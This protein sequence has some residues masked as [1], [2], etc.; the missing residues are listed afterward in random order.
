[1]IRIRPIRV[2]EVPAAKHMILSVAYNIYG[3][4]GTLEE[5]IRHFEESGEFRDMDEVQK[6]YFENDGLFLAVLDDNRVIGTGAIRRLDASACEL[7][8]MWLLEAYHGRGIGY[9]VFMQLLNFARS[10]NYEVMRL[11]TSPEQIRALAF[12]RR[13]GFH[14]IDSY[15]EKLDEISMEL[16]IR[17]TK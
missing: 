14:E 11:Q 6:H 9:Q 16:K 7:K 15:N 5:S 8:R 2:Q 10:K 3:W 12:Y 17:G 13:L 1:M 4:D